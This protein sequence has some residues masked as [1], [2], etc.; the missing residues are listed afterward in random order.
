[1]RR[2][3]GHSRQEGYVLL[4]L[5]LMVALMIIAAA[6]MVTSI[7]S[8]I[9]RERETEMIHRGV[10]YSRAIKAYYKKFGRY[11]TKIEDLENSNNLRFL[12]K[13]YKDPMTG[14][15]FKLLHFGDV[16]LSM[17]GGMG[18]T[19]IQGANPIGGNGG[20]NGAVTGGLNGP[21]GFGQNS[22]FGN[23]S[24]GTANTN[25]QSRFD[26]S[27][28][29]AAQG[30]TQSSSSTPPTGD[31]NSSSSNPGQNSLG[32]TSQDQLSGTTFGGGAIVGV[33]SDAKCP[34]KPKEN[35]EG[36]REFNHK[37]KYNEWQ[38]VY[39]P[40]MDRG[41]LITTPYQPQLAGFGQPSQ[42]GKPIN[43]SQTP[44]GGYVDTGNPPQGMQNDP[45]L[46]R[47]APQN[48]PQSSSPQQQ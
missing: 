4:T 21:G 45:D 8:D 3:S 20:L 14:Q 43:G 13:R 47:T 18:G 26:S 17:S 11:P 24:F 46:N 48:P 33:L 41:G 40:M 23:N 32:S 19:M 29:D 25:Q 28:N 27:A 37:K 39:D 10:Q 7:A 6:A 12:R 36:F 34:P 35:C 38:F 44:T 30:N 31:N 1:M 2:R 9:R 15:D 16:K 22:G 5:L 42:I